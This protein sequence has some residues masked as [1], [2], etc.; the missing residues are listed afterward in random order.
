MIGFADSLFD[1]IGLDWAVPKFSTLS[2]RQKTL[3]VNIPY[4]GT[5]GPSHLLIHR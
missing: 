3:A 2:H 5:K 4:R 1:L